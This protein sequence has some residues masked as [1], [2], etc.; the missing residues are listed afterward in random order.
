MKEW[1]ETLYDFTKWVNEIIKNQ[2]SKESVF[3]NSENQHNDAYDYKKFMDTKKHLS[4]FNIEQQGDIIA[5]YFIYGRIELYNIL[6]DVH[7]R[8]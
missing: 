6:K 1:I 3:C 4:D 8:P 7:S 5:D 2:M